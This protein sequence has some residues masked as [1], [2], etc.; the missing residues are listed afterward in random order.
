MSSKNAA[1]STKIKLSETL[2]GL[3]EARGFSR[4]RKKICAAVGVS[5]SALSQYLQGQ[6]TPSFDKLVALAEFFEVSLDY[7]VYGARE[8]AAL[9]IDYGPVVR[10]IDVA[11]TETQARNDQHAAM[12]TRIARALSEQIEQTAMRVAADHPTPAGLL[13][14]DETMTLEA[15]SLESRIVCTTLH[16]DI[17]Q[18]RDKP[19]VMGR[20]LT[21]VAHNLSRGRR[22]QYLLPSHIGE[23]KPQVQAYMRLLEQ[24]CGGETQRVTNGCKFRS[25]RFPVF[26]GCAFYR[27]HVSTFETEQPVL[28]ERFRETMDHDGWIGYVQPPSG[29]S[30]ADALMDRTHTERG[31]AAFERLWRAADS[32]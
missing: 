26:A 30:H 9:A 12:Y 16:E 31:L 23:W 18:L 13:R 7:L 8:T 2:G 17:I 11:L 20:F 29:E 19:A 22:Y 3:I 14:E 5:P 32:L 28:Y 25:A 1:K 6:A 27:L 4:A 24:H 21:T 10:Y 15:Y